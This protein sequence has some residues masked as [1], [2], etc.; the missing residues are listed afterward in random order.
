L[1]L[2]L[3]GFACRAVRGTGRS[4]QVQTFTFPVF[5]IRLKDY[6]P[7]WAKSK[8]MKELGKDAIKERFKTILEKDL[9]ELEKAQE[10][11]YADDRYGLLVI[12]Q[13]MD[14]AGKDGTI[15]HVMSGVKP[16]RLSGL[17]LQEAFCRGIEPQLSLALWAVPARARPDRHLQSLLLRRR[18]DRQGASR[19]LGTAKIAPWEKRQNVLASAL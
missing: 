1:K 8:E 19:N 17:P 9:V 11:L 5:R 4:L 6:D 3:I 18:A 2:F 13:A 10:L 12:L 7:A 14:A 16:A 15:K